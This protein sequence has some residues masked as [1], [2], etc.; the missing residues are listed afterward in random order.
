M[1]EYGCTGQ[2]QYN[3]GV[4]FFSRRP[5]VMEVLTTWKDITFRLIEE[6]DFKK[7]DQPFLTL[8]M[9][10]LKFN[11]Y[12]LAPT[13][14]YRAL[15]GEP[16][17]GDV[18]LWHSYDPVPKDINMYHRT[19]PRGYR[20][21]QKI[22]LASSRRIARL[23]RRK[24]IS[25]GHLGG[26]IIGKPAPGTWCP[27]LWDWLIEEHGVRTMLD[28]GCGLGYAMKYFYE[29]GCEVF[30]VDGSPSAI[31]NNVMK[32]HVDQHDFS[33]APWAPEKN[34]DLVWSSEF[35]E[36]IEEKYMGNYLLAFSKAIKFVVVTY[37]VPGQGGYH[38]V[39]ENT[40]A[41]W[42]ENFKLIDIAL[43][44]E[45]TMTA[46]SLVPSEGVEGKQFRNKGMV[47]RRNG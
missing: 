46:R 39:N 42:S 18:L 27:G 32:D 37:A 33:L 44:R 34:Y 10:L 38:H 29:H 22:M 43:D 28:V 5:D 26:Y 7:T 13:Y 1:L 4:F 12:T 14:N 9:E 6:T 24:Q 19:W 21:K 8:A 31:E 23:E 16:I 20:G 41:Y 30:G 45:L 47:F 36:H 25:E 40:E 17:S 15:I 11:P 2:Y 35:L 3:A